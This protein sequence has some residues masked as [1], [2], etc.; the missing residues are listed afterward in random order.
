MKTMYECYSYA[1]YKYLTQM[2]FFPLRT[3]VHRSTN[4]RFWVFPIT[5]K[6]EVALKAWTVLNTNKRNAQKS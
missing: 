4:K 2:G 5:A 3:A 1:Q 6:L